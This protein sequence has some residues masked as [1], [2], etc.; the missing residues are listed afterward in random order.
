[1][2]WDPICADYLM[3]YIF[4]CPGY[5]PKE[6]IDEAPSTCMPEYIAVAEKIKNGSIPIDVPLVLRGN[7]SDYCY[8]KCFQDYIDATYAY[9]ANG[10]PVLPNLTILSYPL[11][12]F[13]GIACGKTIIFSS[14]TRFV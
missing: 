7:Y 2:G 1:M 13:R 8:Q 5:P 14:S 12:A 11:K 4:E 10:C 9:N 6:D 3:G